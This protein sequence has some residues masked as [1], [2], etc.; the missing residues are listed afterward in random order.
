[1]LFAALETSFGG[2]KGIPLQAATLIKYFESTNDKEDLKDYTTQR[3]DGQ[4]TL[5]SNV[6]PVLE[7][8]SLAKNYY[9]FLITR[10]TLPEYHNF[11]AENLVRQGL[12]DVLRY[13]QEFAVSDLEELASNGGFGNTYF[14]PITKNMLRTFLSGHTLDTV[15]W[16]VEKSDRLGD[17]RNLNLFSNFASAVSQTLDLMIR[18]FKGEEFVH[19]HCILALRLP[20]KEEEDLIEKSLL[21]RMNMHYS[22]YNLATS[23]CFVLH[24]SYSEGRFRCQLQHQSVELVRVP[25]ARPWVLL[26]ED[27]LHPFGSVVD[28]GAG[29]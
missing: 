21:W 26:G 20:W 22:M 2:Y 25:Y 11:L 12:C 1:M 28:C 27:G 19:Q 23:Q 10:P 6:T 9:R 15:G 17:F 13:K 3:E 14:V 7:S 4:L 16:F 18:N 5:K 24:K 29:N 8:F